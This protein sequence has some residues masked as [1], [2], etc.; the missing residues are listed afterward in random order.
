M[1]LK[2]WKIKRTHLITEKTIGFLFGLIEKNKNS[3][4]IEEYS[5]QLTSL[6]TIFNKFAMENNINE[7]KNNQKEIN[8]IEIYVNDE[9]LN[10]LNI[11]WI[12]YLFELFI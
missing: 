10:K 2:G 5:I 6:E 1:V 3:L 11:D 12:I 8:K 7:N 4:N 9:L